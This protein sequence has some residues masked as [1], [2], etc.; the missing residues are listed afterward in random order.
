MCHLGTCG[1]H[2][3]MVANYNNYQTPLTFLAGHSHHTD[4]GADDA[5]H[6]DP[7]GKR[8]ADVAVLLEAQDGGGDDGAHEG[9]VQVGAHAG[10]VTHVVTD[11]IGCR[12]KRLRT[13]KLFKIIAYNCVYT[14]MRPLQTHST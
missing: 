8:D 3:T 10:H 7:E 6:G 12:E 4:H 9:G 13:K 1:H 5:G 14:I 2:T 11:V